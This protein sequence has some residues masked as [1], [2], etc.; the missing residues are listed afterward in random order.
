[1][2]K[3]DVETFKQPLNA[4]EGSPHLRMLHLV[5]TIQLPYYQLTIEEKISLVNPLLVHGGKP[6][7]NR[8]IFSLIVRCDAHVLSEGLGY[9]TIF[10]DKHGRR[11]RRPWITTGSTITMNT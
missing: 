11:R 6:E 8:S 4:I 9:P 1:V 3:G 7:L 5:L 2:G 10:I